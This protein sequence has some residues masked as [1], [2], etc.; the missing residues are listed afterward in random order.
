MTINSEKHRTLQPA[1]N[2]PMHWLKPHQAAA[3]RTSLWCYR[4]HHTAEVSPHCAQNK[5]CAEL[6][7]EE[8]GSSLREAPAQSS[9]RDPQFKRDAENIGKVQQR[10]LTHIPYVGRLKELGLII[11]V[12]EKPQRYL[13]PAYNYMKGSSLDTTTKHLSVVSNSITRKTTT[14][15]SFRD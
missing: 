6:Y 15:S 4:G 2:N 13:I 11:L 5:L 12:K 8:Q 7:P 1:W 10:C 9:W 3:V 14:Q